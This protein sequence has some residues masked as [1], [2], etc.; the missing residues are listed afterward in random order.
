MGG[1]MRLWFHWFKVVS[2]LRGTCSRKKTYAWLVIALVG[3]CVRP[4]LA[5]V[6]SF[7]RAGFVKE[8]LYKRLLDMFH[9]PALN[10]EKLTN[11]WI[12]LALTLFRPVT[13]QGY[14]L[15]V[16]DG[17]K[18][19]KE[20]RKMPGV[21][22]LHQSSTD[23]SK[24]AFIMGHSF[25]AVGLLVHGVGQAVAS[26]PLVSRI[27]EGIVWTNLRRLTLLDKLVCLLTPIQGILAKK[28]I[29]V[30]DAYYASS[31]IILP[32]LDGGHHLVTRVRS[33]AVGFQKA[34]AAI[35]KRRGRPRKYGNKIELSKQ[36][37]RKK[38]FITAPS[39]VYGDKNTS[40]EYLVLDLLWRSVGKEVRFV[41]VKHPTRGRIILMTTWVSMDPLDVI[42]IY[43]YRFKIECSFKSAIHTLGAYYYHFW[44]MDMNPL[45]RNSGDQF[46]HM[47]K[48]EY[49]DA[50]ERKMGAYHRY[51]QIG[52]VAQGILLYLAI[53]FH[54]LVWKKFGSW[55]RTMKT[56]QAPSE[57]VVAQALRSTL[58]EF[59]MDSPED[60]NLKKMLVAKIEPSRA[61]GFRLSA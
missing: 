46:M 14:L 5:G 24:P 40:I 47:K 57:L 9:S 25:Q 48:K 59:L 27:H 10:L 61:P 18:I 13:Y 16:A 11:I 42:R 7:I 38:N 6:T 12:K 1:A 50:V 36:W 53:S 35:E 19:P 17:L 54:R 56:D 45:K 15:L 58:P 43:G 60:H 8:R 34:S 2:Q 49:R 51:V 31:K 39:P 4:D 3:F 41:L 55:M 52:V 22:K 23:N 37:S 33:N 28:T 21:K 30:A 32:L 26:I 20:G 44:M 29:L